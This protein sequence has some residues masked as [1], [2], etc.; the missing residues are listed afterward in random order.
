MKL[1]LILLSLL[2]SAHVAAQTIADRQGIFVVAQAVGGMSGISNSTGSGGGGGGGS[3][4][5]SSLVL[6][7][8]DS[9]NFMMMSRGQ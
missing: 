6:D 3:G 9:C 2:W 5:S 7:Y 1:A 8:S 4:C